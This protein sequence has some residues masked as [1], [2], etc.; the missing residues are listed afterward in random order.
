M[1]PECDGDTNCNWC[2][3]YSHQKISTETGRFGNKRTSEDHP[4][5]SIVEIGQNTKVSLGD[6]RRIA[7]LDYLEVGEY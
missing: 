6:L 3:L 5:H 2:A 1:E 4:N 7:G